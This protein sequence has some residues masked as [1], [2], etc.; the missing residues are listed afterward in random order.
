MGRGPKAGL[1]D[2]HRG[3]ELP[4]QVA[5]SDASSSEIQE[6][7]GAIDKM[8]CRLDSVVERIERLEGEETE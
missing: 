8:R 3:A 1:V 5:T 7:K 2:M 6:L 4:T